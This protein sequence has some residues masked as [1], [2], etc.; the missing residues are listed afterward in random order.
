MPVVVI[1]PQPGCA[2][3]VAAARAQGLDASGF[4]LFAIEPLDWKL[5]VER[6]DALLIGSANVFR[7]GGAQIEAL[8]ALRVLAVGTA[9]ADA[10]RAAGFAVAAT[11][12]GHLQSLLD[13]LSAD[14]QRLLRLCGEDRV[15][16]DV[17]GGVTVTEVAVYR[18]APLAP[19]A[20]LMQLLAEGGVVMVHS[21]AAARH[22]ASLSLP[23]ERIALACISVRTAAATGIGWRDVRSA[24]QPDDTS[25]LALT[26]AMCQD[27]RDGIGDTGGTDG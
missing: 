4:P 15:A 10:A 14:H 13:Q 23:R 18:S 12:N 19:P 9:T 26:A 27:A 24:E 6:F 1:R 8:R 21:A 3:T 16:V 5:P 20:G 17:P 22:L 2:A 25:L 7:H 11:G